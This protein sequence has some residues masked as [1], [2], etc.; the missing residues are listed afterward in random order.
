L[1]LFLVELATLV[2]AAHVLAALAAKWS[3]PLGGGD[4]DG[5]EPLV[6]ATRVDVAFPEKG[7][8][9]VRVTGVL[10]RPAQAAPLAAAAAATTARAAAQAPRIPPAAAAAAAQ[11]VACAPFQLHVLGVGFWSA[12]EDA[13]GSAATLARGFLPLTVQGAAAASGG[14]Q[15]D[16]LTA[17]C[18]LDLVL[19]QLHS[20]AGERDEGGSGE[21]DAQVVTVTLSLPCVKRHA[22]ASKASLLRPSAV[23]LL[24]VNELTTMQT[25]EANHAHPSMPAFQTSARSAP[26]LDFLH[27]KRCSRGV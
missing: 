11:L 9:V 8:P 6:R 22:V 5:A 7:C 21:G 2:R 20:R 14:G 18:D 1:P 15:K 26:L 13:V 25:A 24:Q 10:R 4:G 17:T 16:R 27:A 3:V 12:L 19:L 23:V